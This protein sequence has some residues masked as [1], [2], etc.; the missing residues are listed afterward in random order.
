MAGCGRA[1]IISRHSSSAFGHTTTPRC[2]SYG[3]AFT[4]RTLSI[5]I[6]SSPPITPT[7]KPFGATSPRDPTAY[8]SWTSA[9]VTA[10]G[11]SVLFWV[12]TSRMSL[13]LGFCV[14]ARHFWTGSEPAASRPAF[15]G[16]IFLLRKGCAN[17][18]PCLTGRDH[19]RD[20]RVRGTLRFW[21]AGPGTHAARASPRLRRRRGT[22]PSS[23]AAPVPAD[24]GRIE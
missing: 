11:R 23:R 22:S 12:G 17:E 4:R 24:R 2:S 10:G 9:P 1:A 3:G 6:V 16:A 19:R 14:E 21:R 7:P 8:S 5:P 15:T 20:R 13:S 18:E